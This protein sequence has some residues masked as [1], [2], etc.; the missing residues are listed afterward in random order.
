MTRA[1]HL[2]APLARRF[3]TL[4]RNSRGKIFLLMNLPHHASAT[5]AREK[6]SAMRLR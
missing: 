1:T 2:V 5:G 4:N 6:G 3:T